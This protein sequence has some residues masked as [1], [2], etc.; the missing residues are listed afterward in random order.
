MAIFYSAA[1]PGFFDSD[2]HAVM[3][4]DAVEITDARHRELLDA[5]AEGA[6]IEPHGGK[7]RL[8][9]PTVT[10]TQRRAALVRRIKRE[11][12]RRIEAI[13]PIWRQL[14]D[15]R[16]PT[17][18][19]AALTRFDAIDDIR[20]ASDAIEAEAAALAAEAIDA[21]DIAAHPLWPTE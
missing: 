6:A 14:N 20:A 3:P 10:V 2:I 16:A 19:V 21:F 1:T 9:R 18:S 11:A 13:A 17:S 7:P 8:R 4:D 5:Q 15:L 12:A